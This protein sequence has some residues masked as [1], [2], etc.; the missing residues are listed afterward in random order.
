MKQWFG[1]LINFARGLFGDRVSVLV[2]EAFEIV[3]LIAKLTP[4]RTD[5]EIVAM[6]ASLNL[7]KREEWLKLPIEDRGFLLLKA[8]SDVMSLKLPHLPYA[9]IMSAVQL[10]VARLKGVQP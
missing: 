3:S 9:L 5:D 4:T 6:L 7:P 2:E 8:A 10:A 1:K